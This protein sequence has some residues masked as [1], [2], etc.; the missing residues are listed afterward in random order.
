MSR[1]VRTRDGRM[2]HR[3]Y[4]CPSGNPLHATSWNWA[5][6]MNL[7]TLIATFTATRGRDPHIRLCGHCFGRNERAAW[8]SRVQTRAAP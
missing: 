3:R 5:D 8:F 7:E 6:G 4:G 2:V 1:Y